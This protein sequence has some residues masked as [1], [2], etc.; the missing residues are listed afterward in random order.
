MGRSSR[1]D[2]IE[3]S[4]GEFILKLKLRHWKKIVNNFFCCNWN[5]AKRGRHIKLQKRRGAKAAVKKIRT[6][7]SGS[8]V[9]K[10]V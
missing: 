4:I 5:R 7:A 9:G 6:Q 10:K 3:F 8:S 1:A 2:P